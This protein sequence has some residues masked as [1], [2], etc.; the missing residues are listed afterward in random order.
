VEIEAL[1]DLIRSNLE[2]FDGYFA[3]LDFGLA[4][5]VLSKSPRNKETRVS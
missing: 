3:D 2:N 4:A 5:Q 1:L